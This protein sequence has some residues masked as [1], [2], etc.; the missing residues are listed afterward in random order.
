MSQSK[1]DPKFPVKGAELKIAVSGNVV[2]LASSV[3]LPDGKTMQA[4][5]TLR[6]DGT[7]TAGTISP[8]IVHVAN[9]VGPHVLAYIARKGN[10]NIGL[11]TYEVF[12]DGRT[13]TAR[14]SGLTEQ[15]VVFKRP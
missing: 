13:L 9:W 11:M 8:G 14:S 3:T 12:A 7:E 6:A 1:L 2:T 4:T 5:E 10:Q 15:V